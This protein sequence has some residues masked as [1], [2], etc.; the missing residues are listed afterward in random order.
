MLIPLPEPKNDFELLNDRTYQGLGAHPFTLFERC[1]HTACGK[2]AVHYILTV[3][4]WTKPWVGSRCDECLPLVEKG[5]PDDV[6]TF[7]T[8][9]EAV[10][11]VTVFSVMMS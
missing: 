6:Q 4:T 5:D 3:P 1:D 11:F 8:K 2:P 7:L 10:R 9:E